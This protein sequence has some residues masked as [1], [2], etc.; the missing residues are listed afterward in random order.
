MKKQWIYFFGC[1]PVEEMKI[2]IIMCV[3]K[4]K[5]KVQKLIWATDQTVSRYNGK[6]YHDIAI[7]VCS[8]LGN[9]IATLGCWVQVYCNRACSL[10]WEKVTIQ[11]VVS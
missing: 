6:L 1:F 9:C 11:L 7:L 2:I 8:G 3:K 4:E 10:A 5:K